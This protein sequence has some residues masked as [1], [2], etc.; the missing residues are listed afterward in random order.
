MQRSRRNKLLSYAV[1]VAG[2]AGLLYMLQ[3]AAVDV[4]LVVDLAGVRSLA[5]EPLTQLKLNVRHSGG[6]WIGATVYNY[7]PAT[8]RNGPPPETLPVTYRISK[9]KYEVDMVL[10][11]GEGQAALKVDRR[12]L[13]DVEAEG[14][15]RLSGGK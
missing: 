15:I 2:A 9:G 8:H 11:Y 5:G 10:Q 7:L 1:L 13:V 4:S 14:T 3:N 12:L 6:D